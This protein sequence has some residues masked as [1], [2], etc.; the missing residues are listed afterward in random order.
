MCL[1]AEKTPTNEEKKHY[2]R[3]LN[4]Y[5]NVLSLWKLTEIEM[6]RDLKKHNNSKIK[7]SKPLKRMHKTLKTN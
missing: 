7:T 5:K 6:K 1:G 4:C 2:E 3:E